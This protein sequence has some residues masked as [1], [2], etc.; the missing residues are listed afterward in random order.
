MYMIV[1]SLISC[2]SLLRSNLIQP[3]KIK[4]GE[5][6]ELSRQSRGNHPRPVPLSFLSH[7]SIS[8]PPRSKVAGFF[9]PVID[10]SIAD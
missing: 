10:A 1:F 9:C 7:C 5:N 6:A 4:Y 2:Q 3:V 8:A